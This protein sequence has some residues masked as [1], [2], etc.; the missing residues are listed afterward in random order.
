VA[1]DARRLISFRRTLQVKQV[2]EVLQG[3]PA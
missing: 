1:A 3:L 2:L